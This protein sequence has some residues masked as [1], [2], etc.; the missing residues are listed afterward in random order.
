MQRINRLLLIAVIATGTLSCEDFLNRP[1]KASYTLSDFYQND[2]QCLQAVNPLYSVPWFDFFRGWL[3]V[4]DCQSGN[5]FMDGDRFWLLTPNEDMEEVKSMSASL[6]A[7]NARANT[8]LENINLYAGPGTTEA[9]RNIA[10]GEALVWK[11][12]AYFYMVRIY[13]AVPIVHNNTELLAT[14]EYNSLYR[15][16]IENVYDYIIMTLKQAI[17]WL[18]E[19][20]VGEGRIDR[21]SACGLLAKVYLTKSGYGREGT[22]NEA[23]LENAREYARRVVRESGRVL[24]PEYADIFRGSRNFSDESLIAWRWVVAGETY[25]TA[26]NDL[27][28]DLVSSG[29]SEFSGWGSWGGP[30]LDLQEAF[31]EKYIDGTLSGAISP[32]R[33]NN[34]KRRKA[35]MMMYGDVYEYFWRDHP[36]KEGVNGQQ[37]AFP[38]GFD[39]A[40][41]YGQVL[42]DFNSSTG[43]NCVKHIVGNNA[44]HLAEFGVPMMDRKSSLAT[45]ILR[46]GDIYLVYA[47]AIL[48]NNPSTSDPEALEAFNA[49]RRRAGLP[50]V[51][52]VTF[53]DIFRERRL[54]LAFEG[55]FWYDFVRLA[56]YKPRE[57]VR[58]LNNQNR[59]NY[60]GLSAY[61]IDEGW[62]TWGMEGDDNYPKP[63][64]KDKLVPRINDET[65]DGK[66]FG[67]ERFALPFPSTDLAMN[68]NLAKDPVDYDIS[69]FTYE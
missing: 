36:V 46:L 61:Y 44:D 26:S 57:A 24:E 9:G 55:D 29:F 56:Y 10:K 28:A 60:V 54:E 47:E 53:D 1:D 45:H 42:G 5:Y 33:N 49:I 48:G 7:V 64:D 41:F 3:R 13:G 35:T 22:R 19:K 69:R 14:G 11:A 12:M 62:R 52:S 18:P 32:V 21:Y 34:D 30:S 17:E 40:K 51:E 39:F 4:G 27:Q 6:W 31:G 59:N 43:A 65:L 50:G 38:A 68:P 58:I 16:K 63:D 25:W 66:P 37:V 23:D 2:E 15:A 67:L 20:A 8:V